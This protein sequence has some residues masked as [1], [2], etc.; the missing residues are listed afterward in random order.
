MQQAS[1]AATTLEERAANLSAREQTLQRELQALRDPQH[2]A[3]SA[4]QAGM[5]APTD[6]CTLRLGA[7][8]S[9]GTCTAATPGNTP[10]PLTPAP[11]K[12]A[13]INPDPIIVTVPSTET[14]AVKQ[15][16][17]NE[18]Q[19]GHHGRQRRDTGRG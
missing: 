17:R 7:A 10:D 5:V 9:T 1:F 15:A 6:A 4:A 13:E 3:V 16:N 14:V 2:V 18:N 19:N 11:P 12:P 8:A